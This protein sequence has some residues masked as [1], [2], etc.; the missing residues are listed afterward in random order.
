MS[1]FTVVEQPVAAPGHCFLCRS[2]AHPP[3]IDTGLNI[4]FEGAI[5]ICSSCL[6]EMSGLLPGA[7]FSDAQRM[8]AWRAGYN[9]A[10]ARTAVLTANIERAV[11]DFYNVGDYLP[12]FDGADSFSP[13]V[14]GA[15]GVSQDAGE[16]EGSSVSADGTTVEDGKPASVE[17][18]DGLSG[19][20]GNGELELGA[21]FEP[22]SDLTV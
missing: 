5:Y 9:Q 10:A 14:P 18:R 2:V 6:Q 21:E 1:R 7:E 15:E 16:P 8:A 20:S 4:M 22:L 12:G 3:F 17:G 11:H 13:A 19:D